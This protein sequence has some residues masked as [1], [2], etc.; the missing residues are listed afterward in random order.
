MSEPSPAPIASPGTAQG[1][2]FQRNL[3]LLNGAAS[4]GFDF[5][6]GMPPDVA[7][8]LV[9]DGQ[10]LPAGDIELAEVKLKANTDKPIEFGRGQDKVS[11]TAAG[12]AFAGL[13]IY[14]SGKKLLQKLGEGVEDF[15][16]NA[17]EFGP[18]D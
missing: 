16:L 10:P 2:K 12:S 5:S 9:A 13:G 14:H 1:F 7:A 6:S 11:F 18:A 17:I 15:S 4:L 8:A 3:S